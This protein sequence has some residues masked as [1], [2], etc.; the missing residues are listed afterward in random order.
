MTGPLAVSAPLMAFAPL[1]YRS[2]AVPGEPDSR[3]KMIEALGRMARDGGARQPDSTL[4]ASAGFLCSSRRDDR[5]PL[6]REL[7]A[8]SEEPLGVVERT[9]APVAR[10]HS[11]RRIRFLDYFE[12]SLKR[13]AE[14]EVLLVQVGYQLR[15]V[16]VEVHAHQHEPV[17]LLP[18]D[19][20]PFAHLLP[21]FGPSATVSAS[22]Q[23]PGRDPEG[24]DAEVPSASPGP[25]G[26]SITAR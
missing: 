7:A 18:A 23:C 3:K 20:D 12:Q 14:R 8:L 15:L 17:H 2:V 1:G 5:W 24:R 10:L 21:P 9:K 6:S 22:P 25:D 4:P 19:D 11:D 13:V 26:A 16:P